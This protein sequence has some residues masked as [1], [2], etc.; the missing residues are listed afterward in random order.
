MNLILQK[1][2]ESEKQHKYIESLTAN[3][4]KVNAEKSKIEADSIQAKKDFENANGDAVGSLKKQI[5]TR[6]LLKEKDV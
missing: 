4:S 1:D 5:E 3:L 6:K 2:S